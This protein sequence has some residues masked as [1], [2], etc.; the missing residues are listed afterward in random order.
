MFPCFLGSA[1]RAFRELIVHA[2]TFVQ[3][4]WEEVAGMGEACCLLEGSCHC[5]ALLTLRRKDG[6]F[7]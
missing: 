2:G 6:R 3:T 7:A 5:A 1:K 4:S